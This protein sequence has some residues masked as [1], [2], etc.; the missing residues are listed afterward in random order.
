MFSGSGKAKE[1]AAGMELKITK[2]NNL[3]DLHKPPS[4]S[5]N[6]LRTPNAFDENDTPPVTTSGT[7]IKVS[8]P[9]HGNP[10]NQ[11]KSPAYLR[12]PRNFDENETT[13]VTASRSKLQISRP[14][15]YY[16]NGPDESPQ[17]LRSPSHYF[18]S[19]P[20]NTPTFEHTPFRKT[21]A[22]AEME[23]GYKKKPPQA[24]IDAQAPLTGLALVSVVSVLCLVAFLVMLGGGI[25]ATVCLHSG[26][27]LN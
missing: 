8:S 24:V 3:R 16:P 1:A 6:F 18:E 19:S 21:F 27:I 12:T 10:F 5:S 22:E 23:E 25:V 2:P 7:D 14:V 15:P 9:I 17:F 4:K 13:P 26:C 20:G 11:T